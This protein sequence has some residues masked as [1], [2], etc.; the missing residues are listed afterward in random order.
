MNTIQ[1]SRS[2]R[3]DKFARIFMMIV[4]GFIMMII[5][6]LIFGFLLKFLW[7][8]TMTELFALP[9]I[10]YWQAIGLFILAKFFFG[11]GHGGGFQNHYNREHQ[12]QWRKWRG[13][14]PDEQ[15]VTA[16][17]E[18]LQKYWEAEGKAAYQAFVAERDKEQR[19]E[20]EA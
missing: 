18:L 13:H 14:K 4:G 5:F 12:K 19:D 1:F 11:F 10:S 17:D 8:A 20:P 3:F 15:T 7:N 9:A 16:D 6:A 2:P